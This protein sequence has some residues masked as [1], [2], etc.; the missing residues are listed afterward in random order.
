M[1]FVSVGVDSWGCDY[2]LIDA[3]GEIIEPPHCYR[4]ERNEAAYNKTI[5][6]IG[7]DE[8]YKTTGIQFMRFNTLYQ[9]VAAR[10]AD[11]DILTRADKLL[12][13]AEIQS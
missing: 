10:D 12:F 9:L 3:D 1:K 6:A 2:G 8:L 13:I 7:K 4:D 5:D 11:Q